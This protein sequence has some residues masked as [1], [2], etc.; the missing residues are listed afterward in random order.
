MIGDR[1]SNILTYQ[2]SKHDALVLYEHTSGDAQVNDAFEGRFINLAVSTIAYSVYRCTVTQGCW[3]SILR[4]AGYMLNFSL[5][6][7]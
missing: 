4:A 6:C 3:Q 2:D 7:R 1:Y 5:F